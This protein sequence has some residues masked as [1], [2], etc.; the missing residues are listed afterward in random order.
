MK[1]KLIIHFF[2][3][4]EEV[5]GTTLFGYVTADMVRASLVWISDCRR[6]ESKPC[7]DLSLQTCKTDPF[8]TAD[9]LE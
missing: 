2:R 9:M 3:F 7:V 8:L 1:A 5:V 6:G 4:Q